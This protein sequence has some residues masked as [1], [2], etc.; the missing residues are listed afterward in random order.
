MTSE[1]STGMIRTTFLATQSRTRLLAAKA[2]VLSLVVFPIALVSSGTAFIVAERLLRTRG[3]VPPAYPFVSITDPPAARAVVGTA[4]LLTILALIALGIGTVIRHSGRN[5]RHRDRAPLRA[6]ADVRASPRERESPDS[7]SSPRSP[8]WRSR[9]RTAGCSPSSAAQTAHGSRSTGAASSTSND[10]PWRSATGKGS[11]SRSR[12]ALARTDDCGA[13]TSQ[14]RRI[15]ARAE[16]PPEPRRRVPIVQLRECEPPMRTTGGRMGVF[17]VAV[18]RDDVC[19][20]EL[21]RRVVGDSLRDPGRRVVGV[22]PGNAQPAAGD[23]QAA[24]RPARSLHA[25]LERDR[26]PAA[27]RCKFA[28]RSRV[29]LARAGSRPRRPAPLRA[30]ARADAG[31]DAGVGER[32]PRSELRPATAPRLPP[33]RDRRREALPVG[34]VLADLERAEQAALAQADAGGDLRPAS[35]QPR[36]RGDPRRAAARASGRRCDGAS[37]WVGGHRAGR[38]DPRHGRRPREARRV[39]PPSVPVVA[40]RDAVQRRL[41]ELP[42]D[43]DGDDPEAPDPRQALLRAEADLA[44]RVR[45]PDEAAGR[46]PRRAPEAA[47]DDA[48]PGRDCARGG[49][50]GSRC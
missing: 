47:G 30:H 46:L 25:P 3:Y 23:V 34:Q 1:F 36:L 27:G 42:F 40:G 43:H 32:R 19:R 26:R 15:V 31:R 16:L 33:L 10:H 28:T 39:R 13:R 48:Q 6:A 9:R 49:C 21:R 7:N 44:D 45:L 8:G 22:R 20:R 17:G 18:R 5:H 41:Q 12:W 11:E 2:I 24:R 14:A 35:A 38:L 29:R 50:R 37:W 4:L